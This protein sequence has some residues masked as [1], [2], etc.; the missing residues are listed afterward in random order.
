MQ[1]SVCAGMKRDGG[2]CTAPAL[3]GEGYCYGHHPDFAEKRRRNATKSH[4][5]RS[6]APEIA[7]IKKRLPALAYH[8]LKEQQEATDVNDYSQ[9]GGRTCKS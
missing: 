8:V 9:P 1:M 6:A 5:T 3:P 2:R 4:K 7:A